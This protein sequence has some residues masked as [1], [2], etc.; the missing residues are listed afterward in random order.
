MKM[1]ITIMNLTTERTTRAVMTSH[2]DAS[3]DRKDHGHLHEEVELVLVVRG[4]GVAVDVGGGRGHGGKEGSRKT[5][6]EGAQI[7]SRR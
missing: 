1:K 7:N 4:S 5:G 3:N 2:L 6:N